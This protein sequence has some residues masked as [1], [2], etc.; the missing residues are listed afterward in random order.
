MREARR[1]VRNDLM[2]INNAESILKKKERKDISLEIVRTPLV[3]PFGLNL[4]TQS[5][6]DF[7]K[8][9]DRVNFLR[10]M[11]ELQMRVIEKR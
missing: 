4:L 3:S 10:R 5:H 8:V 7:I 6:S 1:E 9:E 2:D 11:H